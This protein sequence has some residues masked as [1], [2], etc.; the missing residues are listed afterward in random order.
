MSG[1]VA[2]PA[3]QDCWHRIGVWG[4]GS[5]PELRTYSH[6]RNCPVY[7]A[8][9]AALFAGA[10][11]PGYQDE[12]TVHYASARPRAQAALDSV[13]VFRVGGEWLALP[14]ALLVEVADMRT[15]HGVPHRRG[16]IMLGL[17]NVRGALLICISLAAM[18]DIDAMAAAPATPATG[19]PRLL[20][21]GRPGELVAVPVDEVAGTHHFHPSDRKPAPATIAR[22]VAPYVHAVLASDGRT[23]GLLDEELVLHTINRNLA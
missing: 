2:H 17:V 1:M 7:A 13:L 11:P 16:G 8:A 21:L 6:C 20:V 10:A 18:L 12:R 15:V 23:V 14:T 22:A 5:C 9:A 3:S 19:M 4:D